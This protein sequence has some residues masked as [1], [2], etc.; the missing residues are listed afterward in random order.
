[1]I[2]KKA[3]INL[4]KKNKDLQDQLNKKEIIEKEIRSSLSEKELLLQE[5]HHRAKNNLQIISSLLSLQENKTD[6]ENYKRLIDSSIRRIESMAIIHDKLY[7]SKNLSDVNLYKY[8]ESLTKA[9]VTGFGIN[10]NTFELEIEVNNTSL[11]LQFA[12]P[13]GLIINEL[14]SNS[15]KHAFKG[16][17]YSEVNKKKISVIVNTN[18]DNDVELV[19]ADNGKGLP[20]NFDLAEIESLG[21]HIVNIITKHQLNGNIKIENNNGARFTITFKYKK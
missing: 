12:V 1:M 14:I 20:D 19:V 3:N 4:K 10:R 16:I 11:D 17:E 18:N 8:I 13:C 7:R 15:F 21:L 2:N 5:I 6:D 9:L